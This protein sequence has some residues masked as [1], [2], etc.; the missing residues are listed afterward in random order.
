MCITFIKS[1]LSIL[2]LSI[3]LLSCG[4]EKQTTRSKDETSNEQKVI[5]PISQILSEK[6]HLPVAERIALYHKLKKE[7]PEN[8]R[9][10]E[11]ELNIYG[12]ALLW[13]DKTEE[14]IEIFKLVVAEYPNSSNAYDSL[15]EAY[16]KN[17]EKKLSLVNYERSIEMDPDNFGAEDQIEKIKFPEREPLE[18]KEKFAKVY[19][20]E[21][22]RNDLDQFG[23]KLEEVHPNVY[24]FITKKEFWKAI[25]DKK[26]LIT[27][28]TTFAQFAWHCSEII[29]LLNCSH[30]STGGFYNESRMLMMEYLFPVQTRWVNEKLYVVDVMENSDKVKLKDEI[31]AINQTPVKQIVKDIYAHIPSQGYIQTTQKHEFNWWSTEMIP[32]ALDFPKEYSITIKGAVDQIV[33]NPAKKFIA[34]YDDTSIPV[35]KEGLCL[36]FKDGNKTAIL[37]IPTFN[38]YPFD[39]RIKIFEEFMDDCFEELK[40][41]NTE[42][43]IIDVRTNGG[44]SSESSIYLLRYLMKKPFRYIANESEGGVAGE[45]SRKATFTLFDNRFKGNV[46][47]LIDG[48]GN[49]TTGHFMSLAKVHNL[50]TIIGEELGSNQ[51]CSAGQKPCRLTNTKLMFFVANNT[52]LTTATSLPDEVGI[53][54]DHYVIQSIDDYFDKIDTVKDFAFKL[55]SNEK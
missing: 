15:G 38:Y 31:I 9:I 42:N 35:C 51:F 14:A 50:G 10:N 48:L 16:L 41:K 33:L 20:V 28:K 49:S 27:N 43:L 8:I 23:K 1:V 45:D 52:N 24:K 19:T 55:I 2:L 53:L 25:D 22:Y 11:D 17:G 6:N 12:Y 26:R 47:F 21:E 5:I 46:Y 34:P 30:T 32:Y 36:D 3:L 44:G 37:S 4:T 7:K 39:G 13:N 29:A 18:P 54:P 40:N